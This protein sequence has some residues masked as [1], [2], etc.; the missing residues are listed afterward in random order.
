M[1]MKSMP[2]ILVVA[3]SLQGCASSSDKEDATSPNPYEVDDRVLQHLVHTTRDVQRQWG[4]VNRLTELRSGNDV[5]VL[6]LTRT[7][8]TLKRMFSFPGGFQG[9]LELAVTTVAAASGYNYLP[10]IGKKPVRGVPIIFGEE[11]R[12]LAEYLFD[13]GVRAGDRADVVIDMKSRT[14]Q[15][16]YQG[17]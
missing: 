15:V 11:M 14:L 16:V 7:E 10:P 5:P 4:S 6:E 8:Q 1:L 3:A 13:A 17:F 9:D 12:T 2:I